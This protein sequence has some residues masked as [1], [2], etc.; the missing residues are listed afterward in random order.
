MSKVK[1]V[2]T[3]DNKII[4]FSEYYQHSDFSKFNPI[5]AGF[6]WFDVDIKSEVICRCYGESVSLGL[7]SEEEIDDELVRQQILGYGYF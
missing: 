2:K 4:I 6:V 1:Y 5:S 3:E 7:K